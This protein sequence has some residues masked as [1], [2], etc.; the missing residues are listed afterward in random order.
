MKEGMYACE[1]YGGHGGSMFEGVCL[2]DGW[3]GRRACMRG[4]SE[5]SLVGR[6]RQPAMRSLR[7]ILDAKE[8]LSEGKG[9]EVCE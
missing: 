8:H 4:I 5:G 1:G 9:M 7:D 3:N 6:L 2:I